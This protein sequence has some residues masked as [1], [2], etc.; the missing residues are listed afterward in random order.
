MNT[1]QEK[2]VKILLNQGKGFFHAKQFKKALKVHLHIK[3]DFQ[4][5]INVKLDVEH[6]L[7][8]C[9]KFLGDKKASL[10]S[11][12]RCLVLSGIVNGKQSKEYAMYWYSLGCDYCGVNQMDEAEK[13]YFEAKRILESLQLTT[14]WEYG[15]LISSIGRFYD[16]LNQRELALEWFRK[17]EGILCNFKGTSSY[18][19]LISIM[20]SYFLHLRAYG[21]VLV[22]SREVITLKK[23]DT[24]EYVIAIFQLACIFFKMKRFDKAV[25]YNEE[26]LTIF[27]KSHGPGNRGIL[28]CINTNDNSRD[29]L[30]SACK[31]NQIGRAHV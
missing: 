23:K 2:K 30:S 16:D 15:E 26:A 27:Q 13:A 29:G 24:E 25:R 4:L 6:R 18:A 8:D 14:S 10:L 5:N 7:S 1:S 21:E 19:K 12:Q 31:I 11:R 28:V 22:R 17:S 9:Y 20:A 3:N